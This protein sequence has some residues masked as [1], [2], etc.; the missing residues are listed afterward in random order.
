M[1]ETQ[2]QSLGPED[3][4]EK[5]MAIYSSTFASEILWTEEP[6]GLLSMRSQRLRQDGATKQQL[7][8]YIY[9]YVYVYSFQP[10]I[11]ST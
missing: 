1:Q 5:E 9:T 11:V 7:S 6:G 2:V 3:P 10:Y 8:N 4:L